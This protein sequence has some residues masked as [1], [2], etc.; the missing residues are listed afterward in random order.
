[1]T[2]KQKREFLDLTLERYWT[3]QGKY[4]FLDNNCGTE[5]VKHLQVSLSPQEEKLISSLTPLRIYKDILNH[6]EDLAD[7]NLRGLSREQMIERHFLAPSML[8]D[9]NESYLLLLKYIPDFSSTSLESY[10]N[11]SKASDR[12]RSYEGFLSKVL[13]LDKEQQ[14]QFVMKLSHFERY[15]D[16]RYLMELSKKAIKM[17]DQDEKLKTEVLKMGQGLKLLSLHPWEVVKSRYG[18]PLK[19]EFESSFHSFLERRNPEVKNSLEAQMNSLRMILGQKYFEKE[20]K[21]LEDLKKIKI[22][23]SDLINK[24]N[25]A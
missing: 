23:T 18:V 16:S 1:L 10:I 19:K 20:L 22:L 3:Y 5:T 11:T 7:D 21:E 6:S 14:K 12:L 4:Y 13:S 2:D 25:R 15:L 17:M 8:S 9:I 24:I